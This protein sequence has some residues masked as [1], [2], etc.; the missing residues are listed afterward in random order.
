MGKSDALLRCPDHGSRSQDNSNIVLLNADLFVV[1][2]M[3]AVA[4]EGEE[5]EVLRDIQAKV[6]EGCMDDSITLMVKGLKDSKSRM[7]KGA[8]WNLHEGLVHFCDC[9]YVPHDEELQRRIVAQYHDS[10]V[11][12]HP[13]TCHAVVLVATNVAVYWNLL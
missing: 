8:E 13:G 1:C 2:V 3:E 11:M 7:V 5:H 9:I 6:K 4:V 10:K 12:G